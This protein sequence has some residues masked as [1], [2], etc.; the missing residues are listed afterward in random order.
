MVAFHSFTCLIDHVLY[1][2]ILA[3]SKDSSLRDKE[4]NEENFQSYI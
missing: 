3:Q 2:D 1:D 4:E